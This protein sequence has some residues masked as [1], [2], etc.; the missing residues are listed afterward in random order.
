M[1][2]QLRPIGKRQDG[3]VEF[4]AAEPDDLGRVVS[5]PQAFDNQWMPQEILRSIQVK[6][7]PDDE[8]L[9]RQRAPY[10]RREYLRSLV[11][12]DNVV[13]NRAYL[14]N[15]PAIYRDY[16]KRGKDREDF[17]TLLNKRVIV[18]Y[19][20]GEK[21]PADE[22]RQ[23]TRRDLGWAGWT[24]VLKECISTCLRF[25][26]ESDENNATQAKRLL[27]TPFGQFVKNFEDMEVPLLASEFAHHADAESRGLADAELLGARLREVA[28]WAQGRSQ[29]G[30]RLNREDV[31][32]E[33]VV[34]DGSDPDDRRYDRDKP[35]WAEVKQLVD[36]RYNANLPDAFG[37]Y[38]LTPEDSL[39]RRALQEWRNVER[40]GITDAAQ[41]IQVVSNLR[42]DQITEVLGALGAFEQL[43]LGSVIELRETPEWERYNSVLTRFLAQPTLETFGD[44]EYG[45]Q[46]VALAYRGVIRQAGAIVAQHTKA[47]VQERWDPVIEITVEF[48]GAVLRIFY[49]PA[50]LGNAYRLV[51]DLAPGIAARAAKAVFH[52]VIGRVTRSQERSRVDNSIRVLDTRLDRG[53]RD[54]A[55]FV[56]A[57]QQQGFRDLGEQSDGSGNQASMEKTAEA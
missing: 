40:A 23:F 9:E 28:A 13:I 45:A 22:P 7:R 1:T 16:A 21:S 4:F 18:P 35:C 44:D 12:T 20:Y 37:S 47:K 39:R 31:Y 24:E 8:E 6:G 29:R 2:E 19:L 36:L 3:D 46:A 27:T 48:A 14:Y 11:N 43:S 42:F 49:D 57:L 56:G 30:E 51:S 32:K 38:L 55:E 17:K 33:F 53:R 54:W 26:W 34:E 5:S 15:S 10:V 50:G 52:L 41:L 25:S